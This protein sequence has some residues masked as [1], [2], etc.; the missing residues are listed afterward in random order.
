[1]C[2]PTL[3]SLGSVFLLFAF[4]LELF[5]MI[6]NLSIKPLLTKIPMAAAWNPDQNL[7]YTFGLW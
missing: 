4:I 5:I 2:F 1:M 6:A 3:T 7:L